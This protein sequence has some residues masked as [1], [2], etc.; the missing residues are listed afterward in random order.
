MFTQCMIHNKIFSIVMRHEI[1]IGD[2]DLRNE[3]NCSQSN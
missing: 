2:V 1:T 3:S